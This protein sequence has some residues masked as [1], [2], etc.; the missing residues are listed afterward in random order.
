MGGNILAETIIYIH[1]YGYQWRTECKEKEST[2]I[3]KPKFL[4]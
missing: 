1:P 3:V 2:Y 4:L